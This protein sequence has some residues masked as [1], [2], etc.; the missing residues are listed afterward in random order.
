MQLRVTAL[1][2]SQPSQQSLPVCQWIRLPDS[3]SRERGEGI[4]S[5]GASSATVPWYSSLQVGNGSARRECGELINHGT[6]IPVSGS[7]CRCDA[8]VCVEQLGSGM[9]RSTFLGPRY[10]QPGPGPCMLQCVVVAHLNLKSQ[11]HLNSHMAVV[12]LRLRAT[13]FKLAK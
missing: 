4:R 1:M 8:G 7:V 13:P 9:S 6:M 5:G 11:E 2:P 3:D 12:S 10:D